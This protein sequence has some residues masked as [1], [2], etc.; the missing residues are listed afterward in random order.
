MSAKRLKT[1]VRHQSG[2]AIIEL[3][4][5]INA[6]AEET[7][8]NAYA[9]VIAL[10]PLAILINLA[11]VDY[12]TSTGM[13]LLVSLLAQARQEKRILAACSLNDHYKEVF[14]ITRMTDFMMIFPDEASAL[15]E[16]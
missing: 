6:A 5:E 4:G 10:N 11:G 14:K 15:A 16:L 1:N 13:A 8:N 7:L 2:V 9:Q 3:H 12:I